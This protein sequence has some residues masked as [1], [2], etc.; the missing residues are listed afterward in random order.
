MRLRIFLSFDAAQDILSFDAAQ[1][2]SI[3]RCGSG[4]FY[5]LFL[6]ILATSGEVL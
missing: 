2:I 6:Y 3:L 4:Y 1:D 5:P